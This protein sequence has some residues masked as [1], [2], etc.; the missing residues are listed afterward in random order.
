M[1]NYFRKTFVLVAIFATL[2]T[3]CK[4]SKQYQKLTETGSKYTTAVDELLV[5]AGK[6]QVESTSEDILSDDRLL[7]LTEQ[8]YR[9]KVEEDKEILQIINDIR[10]HN[11]L[12]RKYFSKLDELARSEAPE[13]TQVEIDGIAT[14]LQTISSHLQT[15]RFSPNSGILKGIGHLAI[16]SQINGALREELEKRDRTILQELTIQQEMLNKLGDFMKHKVA[17]KRIAQEQRLVIRPLIDENAVAN[18]ESWIERRNEIFAIDTRVEELENASVALG[19]FKTVFKDSVEGKI[20]GVSLNNALKDID[21]FL[22][23]LENNQKSN[24]KES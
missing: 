18:E 10:N 11:A 22:A 14:N 17:I 13:R 21:F 2:S 12:L 9:E 20:T 23:L 19:E 3:G 8:K 24:Q 4:Y 15:T 7:N 5:K 1:H 16:H 6:L